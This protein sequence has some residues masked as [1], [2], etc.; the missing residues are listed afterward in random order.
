MANKHLGEVSVQLDKKR[1]LKYKHSSLMRLEKAINGPVSDISD[2]QG[3]LN[4]T[5][6]VQLVW[7]GLLHENSELT[8]DEV[9]DMMDHCSTIYIT[10]KALEAFGKRIS[11]D[12]AEEPEKN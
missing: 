8:I 11:N 2:M 5:K 6:L 7:A 10:E 1:V 9:A 3:T 12:S 4:I